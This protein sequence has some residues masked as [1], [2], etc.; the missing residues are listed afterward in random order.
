M[1]ETWTRKDRP[2]HQNAQTDRCL[3]KQADDKM[4]LKQMF[5][6][7]TLFLFKDITFYVVISLMCDAI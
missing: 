7:A 2:E 5:Y 3:S 6:R 1:F 4:P